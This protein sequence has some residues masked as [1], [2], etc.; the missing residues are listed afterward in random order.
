MTSLQFVLAS[1]SPQ[2][3]T[4]LEGVGLSFVV[5]PPET[6]ESL[7]TEKDPVRRAIVLARTKAE[8]RASA[9]PDSWILGS[10]T[11]VVSSAGELLEKP[12]DAQDARRMLSLHSGSCSIVHS[13]LCL[14]SP[15]GECFEGL[16]T[17]SVFFKELTE[18]EKDWWIRTDQ[19]KD[20][21]GGFQIDG[22]G[23]F[24]I[25]KIEGDWSSIV[26]LPVFLLG[27]LL[28]EAGLSIESFRS[29]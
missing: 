13:T 2:R 4:L 29:E 23:Q 7:C 8:D 15:S 22:K 25:A 17:S 1:A 3:K 27:E 21:S 12:A 20:R 10:D 16:S 5:S 6:D 24:L 26:G 14:R 28:S 19:W 18:E 11:L 9:F